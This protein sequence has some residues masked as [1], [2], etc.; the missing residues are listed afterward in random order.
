M[1]MKG[2]G[3]FQGVRYEKAGEQI[4]FFALP[5]AFLINLRL[6]LGD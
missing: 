2:G 3:C 1:A 5:K 4:H 6:V